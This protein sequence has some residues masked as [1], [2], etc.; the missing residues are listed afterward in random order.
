MGKAFFSRVELN[1]VFSSLVTEAKQQIEAGHKPINYSVVTE[2][3]LP[4]EEFDA[5][6]NNISIP[7]PQ[8]RVHGKNSITS[9]EGEWQCIE[10]KCL[11]DIRAVVIYTAGRTFPLYAAP[12]LY[13]NDQ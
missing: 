13:K 5:V 3:Y 10:V 4:K 11:S 12:I 1:T 8:Y 7:V 9:P 6:M 2:I